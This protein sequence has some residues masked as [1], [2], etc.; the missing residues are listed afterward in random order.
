MNNLQQKDRILAHEIGLYRIAMVV[1]QFYGQIQARASVE[2]PFD[3]VGDWGA[4]RARLT[5]FWWVAL[6]GKG[7]HVVDLDVVARQAQAGISAEHFEDWMT[8][9]RQVALPVIGKELTTAWMERAERL[10]RRL[11]VDNGKC[12][13]EL[14][15]AS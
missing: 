7:L 15:K 12:L 1:D 5:Y 4:H 6:G 9:F 14:A 8:L 13:D 2:E 11:L 10:G 3:V